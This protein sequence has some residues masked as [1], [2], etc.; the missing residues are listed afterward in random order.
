MP[1]NECEEIQRLRSPDGKVDAVL[2]RCNGGATTSYSYRLSLVPPGGKNEDGDETLLADH[3]SNLELSWAKPKFLE[4][5]YQQ[6]RIFRFSNFW[7]SA[8]I[9][10]G[11]YIV[12]IRLVPASSEPNPNL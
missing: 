6:A 7:E 5:H 3:V 4:I 12:E 1:A 9:E 11:R 8:K 10:N 2:V